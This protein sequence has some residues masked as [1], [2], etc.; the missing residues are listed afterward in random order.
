MSDL[1]KLKKILIGDMLLETWHQGRYLLCRTIAIP[2]IING[3]STIVE[4]ETGNAI[5]LSLYNFAKDFGDDPNLYLPQNTVLLIKEPYLKLSVNGAMMI[6][7]DSP[8]DVVIINY[9]DTNFDAFNIAHI[10]DWA[11]SLQV[12][13]RVYQ[14]PVPCTPKEW[15]ARGNSLYT[16][17]HYKDAIRVYSIGIGACDTTELANQE[18]K[19]LMLLNRA[20]AYLTIKRYDDSLKDSVL[21]LEVKSNSINALASAA[22]S[23]YHLGLFD[24]ALEH[25]EK[26]VHLDIYFNSS[27]IELRYISKQKGKG[28]FAKKDFP[29]ELCW[30]Y[31]KP[32]LVVDKTLFIKEFI[33]DGSDVVCI[34]RPRQ[35]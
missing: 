4:D 14:H 5:L 27:S 11:F 30:Q 17:G 29:L 8:T 35:V 7:C 10:S 28:I 34:L 22:R 1:T 25:Y 15:K 6:R 9:R 21:V 23:Y 33:N 18:D 19:L 20:G 26:L 32:F 3:L 12:M 13:D 31:L 24:K 2:Y 16:F